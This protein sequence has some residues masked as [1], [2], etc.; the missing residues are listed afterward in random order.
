MVVIDKEDWVN[1]ELTISSNLNQIIFSR[2]TK[3]ELCPF[4]RQMMPNGPSTFKWRSNERYFSSRAISIPSCLF[5]PNRKI[6]L[7]CASVFWSKVSKDC[8]S[9]VLTNW[10]TQGYQDHQLGKLEVSEGKRD[11]NTQSSIILI[12]MNNCQM[13]LPKKTLER[14]ERN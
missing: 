6:F 9:S 3:R 14:Y 1:V 2:K 8:W 11:K 10:N 7:V 13:K 5:H 4:D 12:I